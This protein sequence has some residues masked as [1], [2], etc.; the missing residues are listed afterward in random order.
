M[1][2]ALVGLLL[3]LPACAV[4]VSS[5]EQADTDCCS[6]LPDVAAVRECVAPPLGT[7]ADLTCGVS[8]CNIDGHYQ[9]RPLLAQDGAL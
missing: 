2:V 1:N 7:C 5:V 3:A 6:L 8:V 9:P 4:E